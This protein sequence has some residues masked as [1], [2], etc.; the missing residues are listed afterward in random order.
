MCVLGTL[1]VIPFDKQIY[2]YL[3]VQK[4]WA[5]WRL[6][7]FRASSVDSGPVL[8]EYCVLGM[9]SWNLKIPVAILFKHKMWI[10]VVLMLG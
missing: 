7:L 1:N 10:N 6:K 5:L 3:K 2:V 8:N 9:E 4:L